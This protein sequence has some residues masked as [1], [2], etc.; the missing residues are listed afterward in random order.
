MLVLKWMLGLSL[1]VIASL[2]VAGCVHAPTA[3][4]D[5]CRWT[6]PIEPNASAVPYMDKQFR[7]DI[8]RH[9]QVYSCACESQTAC[10][11]HV[12]YGF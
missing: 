7:T 9:N 1:F 10:D 6:F 2:I 3:T 8:K 12:V 4:S 5:Y 11:P